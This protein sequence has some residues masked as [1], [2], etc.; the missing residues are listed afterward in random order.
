MD[1]SNSQS[2][3]YYKHKISTTVQTDIIGQREKGGGWGWGGGRQTDRQR[4]T[5]R[6]KDVSYFSNGERLWCP[7]K[8]DGTDILYP[9]CGRADLE[10]ETQIPWSH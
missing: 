5:D 4:Q 9:G 3:I 1:L 8:N 2:L 10:N 6:D 7:S